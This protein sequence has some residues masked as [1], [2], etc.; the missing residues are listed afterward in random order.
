M[1]H[2]DFRMPRR[3]ISPLR[4]LAAFAALATLIAAS[5]ALSTS[6]ADAQSTLSQDPLAR[7]AQ[8]KASRP[9]TGDADG[10]YIERCYLAPNILSVWTSG[11]GPSIPREIEDYPGVYPNSDLVSGGGRYITDRARTGAIGLNDLFVRL[12]HPATGERLTY[13]DLTNLVVQ[14]SPLEHNSQFSMAETLYS[15]RTR[16]GLH[17]IP[18]PSK[19]V[20]DR[21]TDP[22][23]PRPDRICR[24]PHITYGNLGYYDVN[25]NG[26]KD[27]G[28]YASNLGV[29]VSLR[30]CWI[31]ADAWRVL[32]GQPNAPDS[33]PLPDLHLAFRIPSAWSAIDTYSYLTVTHTSPNN[34]CTAA[35][36][37]AA[38]C[39][40]AYST[41]YAADPYAFIYR[42]N[43]DGERCP[44]YQPTGRVLA[45]DGSDIADQ[46]WQSECELAATTDAA[47]TGGKA[48]RMGFTLL[49]DS[50]ITADPAT[51]AR[52]ALNS[53]WDVDVLKYADIVRWDTFDY[54]RLG[55]V[56]FTY[57]SPT[58]AFRFVR[59]DETKSQWLSFPQVFT[60]SEIRGYVQADLRDQ[61][62]GY[63][64]DWFDR[65]PVIEYLPTDEVTASIT[66]EFFKLPFSNI[67]NDNY[68]ADA[69]GIF[70]SDDLPKPRPG[71][72]VLSNGQLGLRASR[73]DGPA[74][75]GALAIS[76]DAA[77]LS[78]QVRAGA[79][80]RVADSSCI[81]AQED[82]LIAWT[83]QEAWE[84]GG[85]EGTV[86]ANEVFKPLPIVFFPSP[87]P[88]VITTTASVTTSAGDGV[89]GLHLDNYAA[90]PDIFHA[91]ITGALEQDA[92]G[93]AAP[94]AQVP[95]TVGFQINAG[96]S[97][98][99]STVVCTSISSDPC[100]LDIDPANSYLVLSGPATWENGSRRLNIDGTAHKIAC[101]SNTGISPSREPGATCYA[102]T[103]DGETRPKVLIA[104]DADQ[105]VTVT[106]SIAA[107]DGGFFHAF[108][109]ESAVAHRT[110][111]AALRRSEFGTYTI[112]VGTVKQLADV[113][114]GRA[115][116]N[117]AIPAAPIPVRSGD[118][119]IRLSLLN[120]AGS[121]SQLSSVSSITFTAIG[122][123]TLSGYG[124]SQ[125]PNCTLS[126][127]AGAGATAQN[128]LAK[129]V[130]GNPALAGRID[131]T[132]AAPASAG[133][134]RIRA[135]VVGRD[136]TRFVEDLPL[137]ISGNA[138]QLA[139][140]S[141]M[142]RVHSSATDDD[143]D[144][145]KI[146]VTARDAGGNAAP[147]PANANVVVAGIDG[148]ALPADSY[149]ATINDCN[150]GRYQCSIVLT[151]TA[152]GA[153]PLASGAYTATV[154]AP[155][156][157]DAE[158]MFAVAGPVQTISLSIP[159]E[160]GQLGET[161][162]ATA[163]AVDAAG[164]P[165][166]DGTWI[167]FSSAATSGNASPTA[168]VT[169]PALADHDSDPATP[170]VRRARTANGEAAASVTIVGSG[171]SILTA[172]SGG[173]QANIPVNT[174]DLAAG[175]AVEGA[176]AI[177]YGS[178]GQPATGVLATYRG[179]STSTAAAALDLAPEGATIVWLWNG[180]E[181][182]RYGE[183]DGSPL[184]GSS[185]FAILPNDAIF[186]G[187]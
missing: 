104:S 61:A 169:S 120:E 101:S 143:R 168:A 126:L 147:I 64:P 80:I 38:Q 94:G 185:N 177:E 4:L 21:T 27:A 151:V 16:E 184:P 57:G 78:V 121:P 88:N 23:T 96:G 158:V 9:L 174:S 79:S 18:H 102:V 138:A 70:W 181:W 167:A 161:F 43:P 47:H 100:S 129:A 131:M 51:H 152:G 1:R 55:S 60:R 122:G 132:Y 81:A 113:A 173:K 178:G 36:R 182:I 91:G 85:G 49:D 148:A 54:V 17:D 45:P 41:W 10:R 12:T 128:N 53:S 112:R 108:V 50:D 92:D 63:N 83:A 2:D 74:T 134:V 90:I 186:F 170:S 69:Q 107:A 163:R 154:R 156:L 35:E 19:V 114:L 99:G 183:A 15:G 160:L 171:I 6:S 46:S 14:V 116:V 172:D 125:R 52:S 37:T 22:P 58:G 25:E 103:A 157:A 34:T 28:D 179:T 144:T 130:E 98:G 5:I 150:A 89:G 146:A 139:I 62:F 8:C 65:F 111:A 7:L 127:T 166:A 31:D 84:A 110:Y 142:P 124:C 56:D 42:I 68:F 136:G 93:I 82:C 95:L 119:R 76:D 48:V 86:P 133:N 117:G 24:T 118:A 32:S 135:V 97:A 187:G 59:P 39:D 162:S 180:V 176:D 159:E 140:A 26:V 155:G 29:A 72:A 13:A 30:H 33:A 164:V 71:V 149:T 66:V 115:P 165:V 40:Q 44:V 87:S 141:V 73:G 145:V 75:Y 67:A 137:V 11:P 3:G 109:H 123:G 105:D 106:A 153:A 77:A 20:M 175:A